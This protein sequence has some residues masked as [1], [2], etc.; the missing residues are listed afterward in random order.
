MTL[1][2]VSGITAKAKLRPMNDRWRVL[3][4]VKVVPKPVPRSRRGNRSNRSTPYSSPFGTPI[5]KIRQFSDPNLMSPPPTTT[6]A[7]PQSPSTSS[8]IKIATDSPNSNVALSS[9]NSRLKLLKKSKTFNDALFALNNISFDDDDESVSISEDSVQTKEVLVFAF[10]VPIYKKND[11]TVHGA[12]SVLEE[13]QLIEAYEAHNKAKQLKPLVHKSV[14]AS[15]KKNK[16]KSKYP[17]VKLRTILPPLDVYGTLES[18]KKG[19]KKQKPKKSK[20]KTVITSLSNSLNIPESYLSID[21]DG[22]DSAGTEKASQLEVYKPDTMP[23][24]F[25]LHNTSRNFC[26]W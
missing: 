13:I 20:L 10:Y 12:G 2:A 4:T 15:T 18:D 11:A 8:N 3:E 21:V 26:S 9:P 1:M 14:N 6:D 24:D 16:T 17:K 7:C 25:K 22:N 19:S 5:A 23:K